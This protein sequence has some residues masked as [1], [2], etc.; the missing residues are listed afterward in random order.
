MAKWKMNIGSVEKYNKEE[1]K[2]QNGVLTIKYNSDE[3]FKVIISFEYLEGKT[4]SIS[5]DFIVNVLDEDLGK[6]EIDSELYIFSFEQIKKLQSKRE[7][8]DVKDIQDKD[9]TELSPSELYLGLAK[10]YDN[11]EYC[12]CDIEIKKE[13]GCYVFIIKHY[14]KLCK[15]TEKISFLSIRMNSFNIHILDASEGK[16]EISEEM[17]C[18]SIE[19][20]YLLQNLHEIFLKKELSYN[21]CKP[22][23]LSSPQSLLLYSY[24]IIAKKTQ[25]I[26]I[27]FVFKVLN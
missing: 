11:D 19:Q 4:G 24:H 17:F 12:T 7:F 25:I 2:W 21:F 26:N 9:I 10:Y 20:I 16:V 14:D 15:I 23:H 1:R 5:A 18:F 13:I 22:H 8:W 27:L 3:Y 6:V